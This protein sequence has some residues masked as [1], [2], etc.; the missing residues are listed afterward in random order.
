MEEVL[1]SYISYIQTA[2]LSQLNEYDQSKIRLGML[3]FDRIRIG[4]VTEYKRLL[5][6]LDSYTFDPLPSEN[7]NEFLLE[8][9]EVVTDKDNP[10]MLAMFFSNIDHQVKYQFK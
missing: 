5:D 3:Y 8:V 6:A 4:I 10:I 1:E 7:Q 9:L 2:D